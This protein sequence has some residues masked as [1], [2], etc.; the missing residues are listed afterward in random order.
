MCAMGRILTE[1][2]PRRNPFRHRFHTVWSTS[3]NRRDCAARMKGV[4]TNWSW[5]QVASLVNFLRRVYPGTSASPERPPLRC[6][7]KYSAEL[8]AVEV[9]ELDFRQ[10]TC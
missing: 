6:W 8:Q 5:R 7:C 1:I 2:T 10:R 9:V 3:A 4:A